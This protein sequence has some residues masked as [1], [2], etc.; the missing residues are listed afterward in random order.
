MHVIRT[1]VC[2]DRCETETMVLYKH[3]Y[4][5]ASR[6][7]YS[8]LSN[9]TAYVPIYTYRI[10][11]N[12][13]VQIHVIGTIYLHACTKSYHRLSCFLYFLRRRKLSR[14]SEKIH[15]FLPSKSRDG[16]A[17]L[18]AIMTTA[19]RA[20]TNIPTQ[21]TAIHIVILSNRTM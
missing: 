2:F 10:C 15:M 14:K 5:H 6:I 9:N 16:D 3:A 7:G 12:M 18:V 19:I 4:L 21:T 20:P 13:R 8:A 11:N 1:N 17:S